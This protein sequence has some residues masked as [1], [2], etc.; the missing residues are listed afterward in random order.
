MLALAAQLLGC[1]S[2]RMVQVAGGTTERGPVPPKGLR[3]TGY[4][5]ADGTQHT[6]RGIVRP[7]A[8]G[9]QLTFKPVVPRPTESAPE[10]ERS[11]TLPRR[12]VAT[13]Q[14]VRVN[15]VR[16]ALLVGISVAAVL[17]WTAQQHGGQIVD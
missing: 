14:V 6:F 15:R 16:T 7:A 11:F 2:T 17:A 1:A 12:N 10:A 5:K 3:I 4:T 9:E 13:L 8:R